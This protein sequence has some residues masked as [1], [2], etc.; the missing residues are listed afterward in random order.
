MA[1]SLQHYA[2]P[3]RQGHHEIERF[4]GNTAAEEANTTEGLFVSIAVTGT[5]YAAVYSLRSS[6]GSC[7]K[8]EIERGSLQN[9]TGRTP[10][11]ERKLIISGVH[12]MNVMMTAVLLALT[13]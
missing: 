2:S 11:Q 7:A 4:S 13:R 9:K 6:P 1:S 3:R 5:L 12:G 10:D 8:K